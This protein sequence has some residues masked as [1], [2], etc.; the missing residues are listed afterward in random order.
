MEKRSKKSFSSLFSIPL[1]YT[2]IEIK[3]V[4]V[5]KVIGQI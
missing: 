4:T 1:I 5:R 3:L 2:R